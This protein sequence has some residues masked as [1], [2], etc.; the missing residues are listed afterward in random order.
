MPL[1]SIL[2]VL[3]LIFMLHQKKIAVGT[4]LNRTEMVWKTVGEF[5]N[6]E[7]V[8]DLCFAPHHL[9]LILV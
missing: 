4:G 9:G 7:S 3:Y 5:I 2:A 6:T 1:Y 8:T